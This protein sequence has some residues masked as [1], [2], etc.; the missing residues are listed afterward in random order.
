MASSIVQPYQ[1]A[2]LTIPAGSALATFSNAP[3]VVANTQ[4]YNNEPS[5]VVQAFNGSGAN[6]TAAYAAQTVVYVN[7]GS[8]Q[9]LYNTGVNP[10]VIENVTYRPTP[11]TLNA[12]GTITAA[13]ILGKIITSAPGAA[14]NGT[15]DTG[16]NIDAAQS[17]VVGDALPWN[18]IVTTAF[19]VTLVASAGHTI[20]GNAV[21]AANSSGEFLTVKTAANTFVTY[22][23]V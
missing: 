5:S 10:A 11:G 22:R 12:A 17:H 1:S 18:V 13:L 19:A 7:A 23:M 2:R 3:Y 4:V 6:T 9:V 14:I 15:L 21:V 16:A 8:Q 20:V